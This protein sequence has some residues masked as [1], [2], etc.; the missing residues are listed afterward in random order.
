MSR[1][2]HLVDPELLPLLDAFSPVSVTNENPAVLR[3][4]DLPLSPVEDC[5]VDWEERPVFGLLPRPKVADAAQYTSRE[6]LRR[7]LQPKVK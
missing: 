4:R 3:G 1:G 2:R 6:A 5:G 7:A